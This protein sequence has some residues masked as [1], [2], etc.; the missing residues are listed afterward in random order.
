MREWFTI[1]E[2]REAK[3]PAMD[4][5]YFRKLTEKFEDLPNSVARARNSDAAEFHIS[6]F[7]KPDREFLTATQGPLE[8]RVI[9][10]GIW[11]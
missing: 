7:P 6:I 2:L 3:V 4:E 1:A 11:R 9:K 8:A 10:L 5:R